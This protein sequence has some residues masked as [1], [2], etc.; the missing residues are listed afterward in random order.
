MRRLVSFSLAAVGAVALIAPTTLLSAR[1][2]A[3]Q[4]SGSY[5]SLDVLPQH[6]V[7]DRVARFN[8]ITAQQLE[9]AGVYDDVVRFS[10]R[11]T[12][13]AITSALMT[14]AL[15]ASS[16]ASLGAALDLIERVDGVKGKVLSAQEEPRRRVVNQGVRRP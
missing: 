12:F 2:P 4:F 8:Q 14:T 15:S 16:G 10:A 6:L 13:E 5:A 11:T 1:P 9:P 7:R 3:E